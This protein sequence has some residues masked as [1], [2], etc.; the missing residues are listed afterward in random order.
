MISYKP[1]FNY[2]KQ[3]NIKQSQLVRAD[4][5]TYGTI[6]HM[7]HNKP[8]SISVLNKVLNFLNCSIPDIIEHIPEKHIPRPLL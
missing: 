6:H 1:L 8:I 4:V 3:N 5:C 7:K 2:L